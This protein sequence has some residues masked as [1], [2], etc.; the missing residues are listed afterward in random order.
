MQ[1]KLIPLVQLLEKLKLNLRRRWPPSFV[2]EQSRLR[3]FYDSFTIVAKP[4]QHFH[5]SDGV[6]SNMAPRAAS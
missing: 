6:V 4:F 3:W 5:H 1:C 2:L